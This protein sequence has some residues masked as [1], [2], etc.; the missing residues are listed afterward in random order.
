MLEKAYALD[1]TDARVLMELDQLYKRMNYKHEDRLACFEAHKD[2]VEKRDDL[3][4]EHA[5]LLNQLGRYEEAMKMID[6]RQFH[7]W[8]GGEGKV[9]AQYQLCRLE[10]VKRY[11]AEKRYD[12]ANRLID[13]CYVYPHNLGE[14]KLCVVEENEFNYYKGC[15]LEGLGKQE[16]AVR[17][18]EAATIG[19]RQPAAAMYYNDQKP[20]KIFYQGLALRK[21]G[22]EEEARGRFHALID[23]GEKHLFDKFKMDYFAVSLP[24]LQIWEDDMDKKNV[25]HCEYLIG[26]G[27]LGLGEKAESEKYLAKAAA[28]DVNHQGVQ[29]HQEMLKQIL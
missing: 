11:L 26:L 24:D 21:L 13:E 16:E 20:D 2:V 4:L 27:R 14:G 25:I 5:T 1:T 28:L 8:E 6:A 19:N 7:P 9:T 15:V 29:I 18:F 23:Y 22:R 10:L 12:E 3:Y 17:Y